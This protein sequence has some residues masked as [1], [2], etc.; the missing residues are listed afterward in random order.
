MFRTLNLY[1]GHC[2]STD[3]TKG[4]VIS[5]I[6]VLKIKTIK[7]EKTARLLELASNKN[8]APPSAQ[9]VSHEPFPSASVRVKLELNQ[10]V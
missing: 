2:I 4:T 8:N 3:S 7:R 6:V 10:F 1:R 9:K 5:L